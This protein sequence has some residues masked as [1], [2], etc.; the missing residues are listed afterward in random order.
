MHAV[1]QRCDRGAQPLQQPCVA[2]EVAQA[3]AHLEQH[4]IGA[5]LRIE[6]LLHAHAG[7]EGRR[8]MRH[9]AQRGGITRGIGLAD[10]QI[11]RERQRGG[12][13]L[14]GLDTERLCG[15]IDGGDVVRIDERERRLRLLARQRGGERFERQQ[16]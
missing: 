13:L 11:G 6:G 1:A 9:G 12:A 2:A 8:R 5:A 7:R 16:R 3:G 4:G 10:A 14:A 15:R